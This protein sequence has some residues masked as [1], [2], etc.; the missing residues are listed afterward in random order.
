MNCK[1]GDL[2]YIVVPPG[3]KKT[4]DGRIV[5]VGVAG[6]CQIGCLL[7]DGDWLCRFPSPWFTENGRAITVCVLLDSWLRPIS[8]V[9]VD[10]EI[11]NEVTV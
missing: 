10:E 9:P 6:E 7:R 4:L 1:K 2:A 3:F 5:E 11:T 8:G